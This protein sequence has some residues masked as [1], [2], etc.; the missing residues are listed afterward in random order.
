MKQMIL[1]KLAIALAVFGLTALTAK[2]AP[3]LTYYSGGVE[4]TKSSWGG[5]LLHLDD[6]EDTAAGWKYDVKTG[7][8]DVLELYGEG[9]SYKLSGSVSSDF[10][11]LIAKS[12]TVT[13]ENYSVDNSKSP[14]VVS[15]GAT[16]TLLIGEGTSTIKGSATI[17]GGTDTGHAGIEVQPGGTLIIDKVEGASDE[18]CILNV[19]GGNDSAAIGAI[20]PL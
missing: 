9:A 13:L 15:N 7:D 6:E 19:T 3:T 5:G 2:A 4:T 16:L 10:S 12:C 14:F 11:V 20:S 8:T 1:K 17:T 18:A